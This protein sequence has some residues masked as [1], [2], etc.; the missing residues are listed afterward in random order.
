MFQCGSGQESE[1]P[2]SPTA[3]S[4]DKPEEIKK[5]TIVERGVRTE[6][7]DTESEVEDTQ[8]KPMEIDSEENTFDHNS[9]INAESENVTK[10]D[11]DS[12]QHSEI[13]D[14]QPTN[15]AAMATK[16]KVSGRNITS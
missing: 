5:E 10:E 1:G 8:V 4:V 13:G 11:R 14:E 6:T 16:R 7:E 15:A 9:H 3:H 12:F 2:D